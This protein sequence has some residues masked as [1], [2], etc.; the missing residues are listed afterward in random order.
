MHTA[1][2]CGYEGKVGAVI[3][4]GEYFILSPNMDYIPEP[5]VNARVSFKYN[6]RMG[7]D[8]PLLWPQPYITP[9]AASF[10]HDV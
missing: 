6:S 2:S 3:H 5:V 1:I 9:V 7:D 8:D 10:K 4:G